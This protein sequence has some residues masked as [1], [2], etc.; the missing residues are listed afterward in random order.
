MNEIV[1]V[2]R[3]SKINF[4]SLAGKDEHTIY[5]CTDTQEVFLGDIDLTKDTQ[6]LDSE[7]ISGLLSDS[8]TTIGEHGML[9]CYNNCI[10]LCSVTDSGGSKRYNYEKVVESFSVPTSEDNGRIFTVVNGRPA[11]AKP[12]FTLLPVTQEEYD[13]LATKDPSTLY[14]IK[15]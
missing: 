9:Y 3:G 1:E 2:K 7:P 11:W 6:V 15:V 5:F 13:A 12:A 8:N 14:V 10:Y 4:N